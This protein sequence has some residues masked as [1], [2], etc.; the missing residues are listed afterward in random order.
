MLKTIESWLDDLEKVANKNKKSEEGKGSNFI[1][2]SANKNKDIKSK[3]SVEGEKLSNL[4]GNKLTSRSS[5][6]SAGGEWL[7]DFILQEHDICGNF[8]G[9][10]LAAEIEL[11]DSKI[12]GLRYDFN[13]LLQSD[14]EFK[15]FVFQQKDVEKFNKIIDELSISIEMY[16]HK[17][18]SNLLIAC[19]STDDYTFLYKRFFLEK[20]MT[21]ST[22]I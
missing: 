5:A 9:V 22:V 13:K 10:K 7:Y 21:N 4:S 19:W 11:S 15:L 12:S 16:N 17:L 18:N 8:I 3:L 20:S 6:E 2:Y 14:A 1:W